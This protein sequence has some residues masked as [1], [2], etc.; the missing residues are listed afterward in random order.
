[1]KSVIFKIE[2]MRCGGCAQTI[3]ALLKAEAG[4]R[5]AEVSYDARQARVLYDPK[6]TSEERLAAAV[7]GAGYSVAT[8][9]P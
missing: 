7:T 6:A 1:M 9:A 8:A 5:G 3:E 2:G 4:V